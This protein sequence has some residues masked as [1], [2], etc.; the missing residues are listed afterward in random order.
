MMGRL[1]QSPSMSRHS[2]GKGGILGVVLLG[3]VGQDVGV[4][5]G[6]LQ[7]VAPQVGQLGAQ[8]AHVP[9]DLLRHALVVVLELMGEQRNIL[10]SLA[11]WYPW[12]PPCAT[13]RRRQSRR[14]H[15]CALC[16]RS[17]LGR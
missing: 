4:E 10:R 6:G 9:A 2:T 16:R 8:P 15:V 11:A 7:E 17:S 5:D 14:C 12:R 13:S 1:F 3:Q